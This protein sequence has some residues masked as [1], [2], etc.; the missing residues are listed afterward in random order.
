MWIIS[1]HHHF[2]MIKCLWSCCKGTLIVAGASTLSST[3]F[4]C[5]TTQKPVEKCHRLSPDPFLTPSQLSLPI[6]M[7]YSKTAQSPKAATNSTPAAGKG[8]GGAKKTAARTS[9]AVAKDVA[10]AVKAAAQVA[11]KKDKAKS[12]SQKAA[13]L[14]LAAAPSPARAQVIQAAE[15]LAITYNCTSAAFHPV[16]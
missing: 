1:S 6:A 8:S 16:F 12:K 2:P 5:S 14:T 13:A 3:L 11:A 10:Q 15:P 4:L 9:S 7:V